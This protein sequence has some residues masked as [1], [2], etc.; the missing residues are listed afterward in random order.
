MHSRDKK[1]YLIVNR[2]GPDRIKDISQY[3]AYYNN[4]K[5][6]VTISK[7]EL[8]KFPTSTAFVVELV[9][10]VTYLQ[11]KSVSLHSQNVAS[12]VKDDTSWL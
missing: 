5:T 4:S 2:L 7:K 1:K 9:K 3:K 8:H 6:D 10:A 11:C 12:N